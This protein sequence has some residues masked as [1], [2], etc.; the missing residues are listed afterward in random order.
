MPS[1]NELMDRICKLEQ[2]IEDG[3]QF[4]QGFKEVYDD[5]YNG[6]YKVPNCYPIND[7][8]RLLFE[9]LNLTVEEIFPDSE[10]YRITEI[11]EEGK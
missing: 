1:K 8:L 2:K 11:K 3:T 7:S 10:K 5:W 9:Y 4:Q 6:S